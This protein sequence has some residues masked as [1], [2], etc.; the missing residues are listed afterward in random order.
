MLNAKQIRSEMPDSALAF[1]GYNQTN[2]GRTAELLNHPAY[3]SIVEKHL[4]IGSEIASE[5]LCTHIDLVDRVRRKEETTLES[6]ADAIALIMSVERAHLEILESL[7]EIHYKAAHSAFGYSLGEISALVAGG[8]IA[9]EEALPVPL[10]LSGDCAKLADNV[11]LGVLF[12]RGGTIDA[13]E[14]KRQCIHTNLEGVGVIGVS[15]FLSPN[16]ILLMGQHDTLDRFKKR[17]DL[18]SGQRLYLRKNDHQWPPLHTPIVWQENIP[19]R[20]A[21][22]M[23][24]MKGALT[25]PLPKVVSLVTGSDTYNDHNARQTLYQWTDHPQRL[26]DVVYKTLTDGVETILHLGPEPNIIPAT[27]TR[28]AENVNNQTKQSMG[29]RAM[30]GIVSRP[31]LKRL[32]PARTALLR[33]PMIEHI[34]VEDWLLAEARNE[35]L[36]H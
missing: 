1:R 27:Y 24:T 28:L 9:F 23:H 13:D 34:I 30:S 36:K 32:L 35:E 25:P 21:I 2:L 16:T 20:C 19:S 12:S 31:W 8:V 17:I 10:L 15:A 26:W 6:Y 18:V 7:F 3:G 14:V 4:R 11:T 29:L 5:T 22:L 33:A